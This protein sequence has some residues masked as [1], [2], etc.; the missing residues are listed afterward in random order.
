MYDIEQPESLTFVSVS[1]GKAD[2]SS[3]PF[4]LKPELFCSGGEEAAGYWEEVV[5]GYLK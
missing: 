1:M 3:F 4:S 2:Q 5:C